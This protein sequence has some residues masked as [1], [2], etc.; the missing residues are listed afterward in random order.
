MHDKPTLRQHMRERLRALDPA[1][2][3]S[4]SQQI[5]DNILH[6]AAAWPS[7]TTIALFGG[8]K[9]EPDILPHLLPALNAQGVRLCFFQIEASELQPRQVRSL[10]D[11]QRGQMNV[12]E[13]K[14]HCPRIEIDALDIILVP[15][16]AFTR[17]GLR[18]GRGGGYYD[19]LLANPAC[20][21][22]R[23]AIAFDLQ[24]VDSIPVEPHD[25]RVHQIIT[26][27]SLIAS[28]VPH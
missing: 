17:D 20:R 19:R 6:L 15:G 13:P 25:Q 2:I 12:W 5:S 24:I 11:L 9:N 27:S 4:A 1:F 18:L 10:D 16:L 3:A 22:Q 8:L 28:S 14:P 23:I 7:G 21:A 26:E